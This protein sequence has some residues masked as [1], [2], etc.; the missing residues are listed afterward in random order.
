MLP[1]PTIVRQCGK[2][3]HF[4]KEYTLLSGNT[5]GARYWT[6]GKCDAPMLPD[7]PSLA[8]CP[9]CRALIWIDEQEKIFERDLFEPAASGGDNKESRDK[10]RHKEIW[11]VAKMIKCPSKS[12]YFRFLRTSMGKPEK[13]IY[14]R[15]RAWW[16][17]N[18]PRRK[19]ASPTLLSKAER[20][21]LATLTGLLDGDDENDRIMKA[22]ALR[23]LGDF[24]GAGELL[25]RKFGEGV[26]GAAEFIGRLIKRH[27]PIAREIKYEARGRKGKTQ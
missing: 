10:G 23:E 18:D 22:E 27:D 13:E 7:L 21:N 25:A 2:C 24:V 1:G 20:D 5:C 19:S 11:R 4:L 6:D 17:G 15:I 3:G 8:K 16:A 26:C 12:D 9:H 14:V